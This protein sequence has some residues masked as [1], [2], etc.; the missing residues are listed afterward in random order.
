MRAVVAL[1]LC[2]SSTLSYAEKS[3][4]GAAYLVG[5]KAILSMT[6]P[7]EIYVAMK[8]G[9][10]SGVVI[11]LMSLGALFPEPW[12]SCV[13]S[14]TIKL[15]AVAVVVQFLETNPKRQEEIFEDLVL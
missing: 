1:L 4:S 9:E 10:C 6:I 5:C 8:Q 15:H 3:S 12:R 2:L 14:S 13:P 7:T 11:T